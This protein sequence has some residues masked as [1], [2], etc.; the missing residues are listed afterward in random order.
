MRSERRRQNRRAFQR[1]ANQI[2]AEGGGVYQLDVIPFLDAV[3]HERG[4]RVIRDLVESTTSGKAPLCLLCDTQIDL[5]APPAVI[6]AMTAHCDAPTW[7]MGNAVCYGCVEP[8]ETLQQRVVAAYRAGIIS[9]L[10]VLPP[11]HFSADGG[12]A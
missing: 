11:E 1:T 4:C 12:R 8:W 10:R 6:V 2:R 9:D 5:A 3:F 7:M